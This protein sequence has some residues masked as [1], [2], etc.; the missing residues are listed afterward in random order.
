MEFAEQVTWLKLKRLNIGKANWD[1]FTI[2]FNFP[3]SSFDSIDNIADSSYEKLELAYS[4]VIPIKTS[5]R[6]NATFY[7]SSNGIH[8]EKKL[9][10]ALKNTQSPEKIL[11]LREE[12]S[13][14]INN[15][16]KHFVEKSKVWSTF[17]AYKLM[18]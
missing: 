12:L 6:T 7:L 16:K 17:D 11:R 1:K 9:K 15:D 8:L 14:S 13:I 18:R 3:K 2:N 10:T 4:N 5:E